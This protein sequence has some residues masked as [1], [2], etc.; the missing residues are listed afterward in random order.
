MIEITHGSTPSGFE[1]E[2]IQDAHSV[3][4]ALIICLW[5][6]SLVSELVRLKQY[7]ELRIRR[8]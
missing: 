7:R 2:L 3:A 8:Q 4:A 5:L 6:P 1:L